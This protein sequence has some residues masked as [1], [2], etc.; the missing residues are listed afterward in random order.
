MTRLQAKLLTLGLI[1]AVGVLPPAYARAD[2]PW[3]SNGEG[4]TDDDSGTRNQ[5]VHGGKQTHDAQGTGVNGSVPDF[6]FTR[7]ATRVRHSYEARISG[8]ASTLTNGTCAECVQFDRVN[9]AGTILQAS[10]AIDGTTTGIR[11]SHQV[12]RWLGTANQQEFVR[13]RGLNAFPTNA[14]DK[15]DIEFFDTTYFGPRFNQSGGQVTVLLIQNANKDITP[16]SVTGNI[17]FYNAAGTL[18]ATVAL[19]VPA[20]GIQVVSTAAI[21]A[22]AGQS[23][24]VTIA[25]TGGYGALAGKAVALE[26]AT[27]FSFDTPFEPIPH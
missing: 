12:L 27:G 16:T 22:L 14:N 8:S 25:H 5:L 24:A 23:G 10:T 20:D 19:S 18:L 15:Y 21:P 7:V 17:H 2:D 11:S 9:A 6:D 1:A 4:I 3:E 13:V 26:P